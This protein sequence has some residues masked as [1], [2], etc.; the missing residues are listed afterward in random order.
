MA[1]SVLNIPCTVHCSTA[2]LLEHFFCTVLMH[3]LQL[4]V[5]L[6]KCHVTLAVWEGQCWV[7]FSI[8]QL[9]QEL[10][11]VVHRAPCILP[12]SYGTAWCEEAEPF[13]E[14]WI[15]VPVWY[16]VSHS[17]AIYVVVKDCQDLE[18]KDWYRD[19]NIDLMRT[20]SNSDAIYAVTAINF[21]AVFA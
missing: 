16:P 20:M 10:L 21:Y 19:R 9:G 8:T 13:C 7:L 6:I 1:K 17:A 3:L 5:L 11:E 14:P 4:T 2:V 12:L 18:S 15:L